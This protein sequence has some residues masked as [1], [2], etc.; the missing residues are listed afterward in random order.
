MPREVFGVLM[1][2]EPALAALAGFVV[3]GQALSARQLVAMGMVTAASIGAT[4]T[5]PPIDG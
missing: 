1:S 4:R 3:L 5:T 2:L